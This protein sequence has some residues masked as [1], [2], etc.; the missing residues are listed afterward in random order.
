MLALE[1]QHA[2]ALHLA[3]C[4]R[5]Q[6]QDHHHG[7]S[8]IQRA[9]SIDPLIP[10]AYD[11]VGQMLCEQGR[12]SEAEA[13]HRHALA[14]TPN[15]AE[16]H[17]HLGVILSRQARLDE[18]IDSCWRAIALKPDFAAAHNDLGIALK[19]QGRVE[20]AAESYRR[21]IA[22][23]PLWN[24]GDIA[25]KTILLYH[26]QEGDTVQFLRYAGLVRRAAPGSLSRPSNPSPGSPPIA[27]EWRRC[28]AR[29]PN[30]RHSICIARC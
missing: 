26:Q 19:R 3:G 13:S 21:A 18:A 29:G 6:Q 7:I 5:Y 15:S 1:P 27:R 11:N 14:I 28:S 10:G 23:Q 9:L 4:V 30:H 24:G 16:A 22:A 17:H 20:E 2:Q 25:G 8:L 12:L